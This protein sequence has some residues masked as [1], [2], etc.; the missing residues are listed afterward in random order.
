M[1]FLNSTYFYEKCRN[2]ILA[3]SSQ[4]HAHAR[5]VTIGTARRAARR[6]DCRPSLDCSAQIGS[7]R[8]RS[9]LAPPPHA[10]GVSVAYGAGAMRCRRHCSS[11]IFYGGSGNI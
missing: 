3:R 11:R 7:V 6:R 10:A 9:V 4:T 2:P 8:L 1:I 5:T